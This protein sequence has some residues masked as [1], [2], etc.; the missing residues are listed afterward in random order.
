M[1]LNLEVGW[2]FEEGVCTLVPVSSWVERDADTL[3]CEVQLRLESLS[4]SYSLGSSNS[5]LAEASAS[6]DTPRIAASTNNGLPAA[7]H[8]DYIRYRDLNA[9]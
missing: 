5:A 1:H 6:M 4:Q 3:I 9:V 2:V 8:A 7:M